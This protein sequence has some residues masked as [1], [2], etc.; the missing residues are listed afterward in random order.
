MPFLWITFSNWS[1]K[2][3]LCRICSATSHVRNEINW[4]FQEVYGKIF[5]DTRQSIQFDYWI[6]SYCFG[7]KFYVSKTGFCF[8]IPIYTLKPSTV[9]KFLKLLH[10]RSSKIFRLRERASLLPWRPPL[11]W[12][13]VCS[14]LS[15]V[16]H[17]WSSPS[18]I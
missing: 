7:W 11:A 1:L 4:S 18:A 9:S 17:A 8:R 15:L 2:F 5:H 6:I 16:D 3:L 13:L 12:S 14:F 10:S